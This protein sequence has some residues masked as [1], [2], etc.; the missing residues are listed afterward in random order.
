MINI[1]VASMS[2]YQDSNISND[3]Q[4]ACPIDTRY[5]LSPGI[6]I[7][8]DVINTSYIS[9]MVIIF[10]DLPMLLRKLFINLGNKKNTLGIVWDVDNKFGEIHCLFETLLYFQRSMVII[11]QSVCDQ[12]LESKIPVIFSLIFYTIALY[13]TL[14]RRLSCNVLP[15]SDPG[16][17]VCAYGIQNVCT[18]NMDIRA[19]VMPCAKL[20]SVYKNHQRFTPMDVHATQV[21]PFQ[22]CQL[23]YLEPTA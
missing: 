10:T 3:R 13:R 16:G 15:L 14:F 11:Q 1:N 12:Y 18:K 6:I 7:S 2:E 8:F 23:V 20:C 22:T 4:V 21:W 5:Q 17:P 9:L 19:I